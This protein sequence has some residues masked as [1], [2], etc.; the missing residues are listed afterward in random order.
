MKV[1]I[2]MTRHGV[3]SGMSCIPVLRFLPSGATDPIEIDGAIRNSLSFEVGDKYPVVYDPKNPK[4]A[5]E[6]DFVS[7]WLGPIVLFGFGAVFAG[8]GAL[9]YSAG[10]DKM[11]SG[12]F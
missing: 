3:Q 11:N 6:P 10:R 8:C 5:C 7:M 9:F 4:S 12:D 1:T 2:L